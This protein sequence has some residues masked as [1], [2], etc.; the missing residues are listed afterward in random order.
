MRQSR[1]LSL[2]ARFFLNHRRYPRSRKAF[3]EGKS[4]AEILSGKTLPHWLEELGFTWFNYA[5]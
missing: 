5:A 4:Q 3:R 1:F 2:F